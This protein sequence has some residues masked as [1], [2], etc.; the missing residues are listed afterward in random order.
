MNAFAQKLPRVC[1]VMKLHFRETLIQEQ[2][3]IETTAEIPLFH[4]SVRQ[5]T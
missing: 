2:I 3:K 1:S 4:R 5:Q